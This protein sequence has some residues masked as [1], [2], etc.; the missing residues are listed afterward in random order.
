MHHNSALFPLFWRL[1]C[2]TLRWDFYGNHKI[3][4]YFGP[5]KMVR[6]RSYILKRPRVVNNWT[7]LTHFGT[8]LKML[9]RSNRW[10]FLENSCTILT[11]RIPISALIYML[12]AH[13]LFGTFQSHVNTNS[14]S[15]EV[16]KQLPW[17]S[18]ITSILQ[19][20]F[21]QSDSEKK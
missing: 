7:R 21:R 11:A 9:I 19:S 18:H 12:R 13:E 15:Y 4:W 3:H 6:L 8:Y 14:D 2:G 20:L 1:L 10:P 5:K 16:S 17:T